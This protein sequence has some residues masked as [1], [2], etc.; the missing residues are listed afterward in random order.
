MGTSEWAKGSAR[1]TECEKIL[2]QTQRSAPEPVAKTASSE[3][4]VG[5][6]NGMRE[7]IS[8]KA[9]ELWQERGHR[10]GHDLQDW[11]DAE[12]IVMEEIHEARK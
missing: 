5:L 6:P 2:R 7:R 3:T 10:D 4:L 12:A 8:R 11:L 9:H 1:T